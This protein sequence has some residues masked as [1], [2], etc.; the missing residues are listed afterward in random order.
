MGPS[1]QCHHTTIDSQRNA[2]LQTSSAMSCSFITVLGFLSPGACIFAVVLYTLS[3]STRSQ[4]TT[5]RL[6]KL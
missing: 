5:R 2:G 4:R 6:G 1:N 3:A